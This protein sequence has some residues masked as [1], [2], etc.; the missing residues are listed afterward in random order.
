VVADELGEF[1][2]TILPTG[3]YSMVVSAGDF[4]VVIPSL[5]LQS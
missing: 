3:E 1:T 4:E 2:F 5:P